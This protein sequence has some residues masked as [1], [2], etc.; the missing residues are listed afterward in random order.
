M[1][2]GIAWLLSSKGMG[3]RLKDISLEALGLG[4]R[5]AHDM[6]RS[7][8][9]HRQMTENEASN[10]MDRIATSL[11]WKG[12]DKVEVVI[13]AVVE[14]ME[15][16]KSVLAELEGHCSNNTLICSNTSALSITEMA[17]ALKKPERFVGM[18]FFNPV[19]RMPLVEI[20][21]GA[22]T[23]PETTNRIF[24]LARDLGKTPIVVKD[25]AGF[26]VNR[27]LL[28]TMNE[29]ARCLEDG[30]GIERVDRVMTTFGLPMGPFELTDEVGIEVGYH[31]AKTL[32]K[33]Y[34]ERMKVSGVLNAV[35]EEMGLK[36]KKDGKGF[37]LWTGQHKEV[38]PT[39]DARWQND[40]GPSDLEILDR[41]ILTMAN[42]S[43]RCL[44][45]GVIHSAMALDMAMV[46]GT[47]FPP[48]R[49]GPLR[50]VETSGVRACCERLKVLADRWG[51]RFEPA[52][53]LLEHAKHS[54]TFY[55][56]GNP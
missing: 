11:D 44:E 40:R 42:E 37:Y 20:I 14:R 10:A 4:L 2:G 55:Q 49:G 33:A 22:K 26:L 5:S 46:L 35:K 39:L 13:E 19:N 23:S 48:F 1:G 7:A 12:F 3:V 54:R 41:C 50:Y 9:K 24:H 47:G 53:L 43:L 34:G 28:A 21:P 15:V 30:A 6:N 27:I 16:K 17:R 29:A 8:I 38:N 31:V 45:E 18:H 51:P 56:R 32:E 25:V 36:G 52:P